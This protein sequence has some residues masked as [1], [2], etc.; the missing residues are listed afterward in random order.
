M[1]VWGLSG[2]GPA[3]R[4]VGAIG[5]PSAEF[6]E[7]LYIQTPTPRV[8]DAGAVIDESDDECVV[9]ATWCFLLG[10]SRLRFSVAR[11]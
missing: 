1:D 5:T 4:R 11:L 8:N 10:F 7:G 3:G 9:M 2:S 6:A